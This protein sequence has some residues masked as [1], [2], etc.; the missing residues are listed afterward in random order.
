MKFWIQELIRKIKWNLLLTDHN[1]MSFIFE[2]AMLSKVQARKTIPECCRDF[3]NFYY[4][5]PIHRRLF[6]A[7]PLLP[8]ILSPTCPELERSGYQRP[9]WLALIAFFFSKSFI[10]TSIRSALWPLSLYVPES[11]LPHFGLA[12]FFLFSY[13]IVRWCSRI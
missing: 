1:L 7:Y 10:L 12:S 3:L 5:T 4:S 8:T 11:I 13:L 6:S 2:N 9:V